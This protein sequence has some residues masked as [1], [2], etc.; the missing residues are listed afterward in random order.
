MF[1]SWA[2][3]D[4]LERDPRLDHDA[5]LGRLVAGAAEAGAD[6]SFGQVASGDVVDLHL[7]VFGA[8]EGAIEG[9]GGRDRERR[10]RTSRAIQE[11]RGS[12][13][14]PSRLRLVFDAAREREEVVESVARQK[15]AAV[16]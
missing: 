7:G 10:G 4:G 11:A 1:I 6:G 13:A 3:G 16:S 12:G 8:H 9:E 5:L 2:S 15:G 14:L